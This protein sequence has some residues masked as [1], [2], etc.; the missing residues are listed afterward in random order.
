[1]RKPDSTPMKR[2]L[3][4][5]NTFWESP[6][7]VGA[8]HLARRFARNGWEVFFLANAI[9][10]LSLLNA[11]R[12]EFVHPQLASWRAGAQ[13]ANGLPLHYY[14]PMALASHRNRRFLNSR[15]LLRHWVRFTLPPLGR[16]LRTYG[17]HDPD[18]MMVDHP[19]FTSLVRLLRPKKLCLR[20]TDNLSGFQAAS[21]AMIEAETELMASAP[22]LVYTSPALEPLVRRNRPAGLAGTL[23]L[24]NGVHF[25]HFQEPA[26]LPE[27]YARLPR[28]ICLYV[29]EVNH[30]FDA[31]L[32]EYCA[33][34]M[35]QASFVVVG[36]G[37]A[38]AA[39]CA[40]MPNVHLLGTRP[41]DALPGYLQ[42][43]D[44]GLI[45]FDVQGNRALVDAISPL[46]LL[47]YM[48][49]GLPVVSVRWAGLE[50]MRSPARLA[51]TPGEFL[52]LIRETLAAPPQQAAL[53]E[54]AA[55]HDWDEKFIALRDY[56]E[57]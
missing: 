37:D 4:C 1:M 36:P 42:H 21:L 9:I 55:Q 10:P 17:F 3:W 28:P 48:A 51:D 7:Q 50:R 45:P 32:L 19:L 57:E 13:K 53:K 15:F 11:A 46:K 31:G 52:G 49:S 12:R 2:I 20:I 26:P 25:K 56:L 38:I 47:E 29:G 41:Y 33:L 34:G 39:R 18:V 44:V 5:A 27:E 23:C 40:A 6:F 8:N 35:P 22:R 16:L 54:Y 24:P 14:T 43:A 30:W